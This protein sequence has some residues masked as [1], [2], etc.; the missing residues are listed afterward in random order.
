MASTN[1]DKAWKAYGKKDPYFGVLTHEKFK[2][3]NLNEEHKKEFFAT[4][5]QYANRI[6]RLIHTHIDKDFKPDSI[7]A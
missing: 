3:K 7:L 2:D 5:L 4:G 1:S 6:F